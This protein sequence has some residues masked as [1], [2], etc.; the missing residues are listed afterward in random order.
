MSLGASPDRI[1]QAGRR[2]VR[3][4]RPAPRFEH[5]APSAQT[6][7]DAVGIEWASRLP[8]DD[9]RTGDVELFDDERVN[10]A[11]ERLGGAQ[12]RSVL[13]LGPL[14]GAHSAMAQ[15]AGA[16]RV[17][18]VE[19]NRRAYLKCLV[20]KDLLELDR[21]QFLCGDAIGYLDTTDDHFDLCMANG[22]LYHMTEPVRMLDLIG[23]RA[24]RLLLWTHYYD[25]EAVAEALVARSLDEKPVALEHN[26]YRYEAHRYDYGVM[27]RL[28][29]FWGGNE[30]YSHWL[31]REHLLGALEHFGW[32]EIEVAFEER[33]PHGPA[34]ALVATR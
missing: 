2:V 18:A 27:S 30:A 16:A 24:D 10:W 13:E 14:E 3:T 26:G 19:S 28:A 20:V 12:D 4:L 29:G 17:V 1:V 8:L 21:C 11:F 9:V 23:R 6:A 15:R 32:R 22:I 31:P 7:V 34:L 5:R 33:T 25:A